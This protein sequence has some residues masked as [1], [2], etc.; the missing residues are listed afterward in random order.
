M[1]EK[2]VVINFKVE[3]IDKEVKSVGELQDAI[4]ELGT[5]TKKTKKEVDDQGNA[6]SLLKDRFNNAIGG[7]KGVVKGMGTLKG[8]LISSG[9]GAFVVLLGTLVS[10]FKNSE[11]GSRKFQIALEALNVVWGTI[12]S[13]LADV[14][15]KLVAIFSDPQQAL[16]DFGNLIKE[17]L[18][19]RFNG[20]LELIPNLGKAIGLLFKGEFEEAGKVA[21]DAVAKVGLGIETATDKAIEFGNSAKNAFNAFVDE[22]NR[23][24]DVAT[25][26]VDAQRALVK[27]N[28]E[29][30]IQNAKLNKELNEQQRISKDTTKSLEERLNALDQIDK[31]QIKQA[32][33]IRTQAAAQE[34]IIRLQ[35]QEEGNYEARVAL[36][37]QLAQATADRINAETNLQNTQLKGGQLRAQLLQE[38]Q[39]R[40]NSLNDILEAQGLL[41]IENTLQRALQQLDIEE[42]KVL[43]EVELLGASEEQ[44]EEIRKSF[45]L[46]R[47]A[48]I[49][50]N[51]SKITKILTESSNEVLENVF[52]NSRK[53]LEIQQQKALDELILL[54]ATE[55]EKQKII[56]AFN[57][58]REKIAEDEN[59]YNIQLS[60]AEADAKLNI[61]AGA[62]D[63]IASLVGENSKLGKA[64]AVASAIIDT[65][66]G[67][68][69]AIGSAPPPY[70][71]IAAA[72]TVAS[73]LANVKKILSTKTPG[74]DSGGTVPNIS[75]P[76][77]QSFD[78][79][80][81]LRQAS[82]SAR[83]NQTQVGLDVN[84]NEPIKAYVVSSDMSSQQEKDRKINNLTRL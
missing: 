79:T 1:N 4:K 38:E 12:Q 50:D 5:E 76:P 69:A 37:G 65:Y 82:E 32:E 36:E 6:L 51:Q 20:L 68:N 71:F 49:N 84:R 2:D 80:A 21:V 54:N 40:L 42:K 39:D 23:A 61:L 26:L 63:S 58:K 43:K 29:L 73:G 81:G 67:A 64:A 18:V 52:D 35:I 66:R 78:P 74:G 83:T 15:Q 16:K 9:V 77:T 7:I 47:I 11:E 19:N 59:K 55:E 8:A 31:I 45:E 53:E 70:N 33:N 30:T 75:A 28:N 13:V 41:R 57:K 44:K 22:V 56:E 48:S 14:G 60:K 27:L 62:F 24:V 25:R 46:K 72:A 10:Y 3:G 17:N 34:N